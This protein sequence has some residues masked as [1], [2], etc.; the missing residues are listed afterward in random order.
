MSELFDIAIDGNQAFRFEYGPGATA[1]V[2]PDQAPG[3]DGPVLDLPGRKVKQVHVSQFESVLTAQTWRLTDDGPEQLD[4]DPFEG[5]LSADRLVQLRL[6]P[7][8]PG[9]WPQYPSLPPGDPMPRNHESVLAKA[10]QAITGLAPEG[11]QA[12]TV[13][14]RAVGR[15]ME[16][17]AT[18]ALADGVAQSWAP[19][20]MVGQW[21]HRL[22]MREFRNSLGTW[23]T[24]HF[25]F[26]A[27]G[28]TTRRFSVEGL[29]EWQVSQGQEV[30]Q[31][32]DELR[33]LPRRPEAVP[34]WMWSAAGKIQ[35][36][37]RVHT[38]ALQEHGPQQDE[39]TEIVRTFDAIEDGK[40]V[41]Y[42]P[43]VGGRE[44]A[45]LLHYL[46]N[47]PVVLSSRGSAPD[48]LADHDD[49]VVPLGYHTDGRYVWPSGV[50]YYLREHA[51]P[52][53]TALVD[54]IR[55]N[56]YLLPEVPEI[57]KARAAALAMGMPYDESRVE[58]AFRKALTPVVDVII[59]CQ[60]SPRHYQLGG[61][62]DRSWCLVRDGDWYE[63]HWAD[64]EFKEKRQR[65]A[66]VRDAVSYLAG[67]LVVNQDELRY[68]VDEE[69]PAWQAPFQVLSEL[70]LP[71]HE[72]TGV[73]L[74][75][76][77]DL[78]VDRYGTP[79][80]NSVY[81]AET[82]FDQRGLP[83]DHADR[84]YH[85]YRLPGTWN[86][87]TAESP[88]GGRLYVLPQSI[89]A[90][91][92][93]GQLEDLSGHPGLPPVSDGLRAEA[94]R[95]PGGWVWCA[96][97]DV[98]PRY[99][100]GMPNV[101]VLGA[102]KVGPDGQ[103]T[104]E[105]FLNHEYRP[106]PRRRGF[107]APLSEF[108][109]VLGYVAAGWLPQERILT[110]VLDSNFITETNGSGGLRMGVDQG[111]KRFIAVYSAPGHVPANAVSPMQTTGRALVP[112]LAGVTLVINPGGDL[113]MDLP[114]DD[115]V[116]A[117]R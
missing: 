38:F 112:V 110:A 6:T 111:G 99:I 43:M 85:R 84:E 66:D 96:D 98:D 33:L 27:D 35:Q 62:Q 90:Y 103:L 30:Q 115:V 83:F 65:F 70:D 14:C 15:R 82:P 20:V 117:A 57:A 113:G 73:R 59:R 101:T 114:G 89:T 116:A 23:Y 24:A 74:T 51:V 13:D 71:L 76:V 4:L 3:I 26:V 22:R 39:T 32:A 86:V 17:E 63:V 72:F 88:A 41:W 105:T 78:M 75:A 95:N 67:Q 100:E 87:I 91:V 18:V 60:T 56:R 36:S 107:P 106:S 16:V 28:E 97:P 42:R 92:E 10:E 9:E 5:H 1:H 94:Q 108:D 53:A 34:E 61:H 48:L 37:G 44:S 19:P 25:E 47:A 8:L 7:P 104:G 2:A 109:R 29:P 80:G 46:E 55:Q 11:W 93:A 58:T 68:E 31:N 40:G 81:A 102:Y 69:L 12:L 52:P 54:H 64:G 50:A 45:M 49:Q 79:D 77:T 21:L